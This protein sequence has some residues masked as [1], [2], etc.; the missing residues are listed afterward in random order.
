MKKDHLIYSTVQL[1]TDTGEGTGLLADLTFESGTCVPVVITNT[2]VIESNQNI[3]II[4]TLQNK[5][6]KY[7][8]CKYKLQNVV[9]KCICHEKYDLCAIP[10]SLIFKSTYSMNRA[11]VASF[12]SINEIAIADDFL[13]CDSIEDVYV[14]GYPNAF[15]DSKNNLPLARKGITATPLFADYEGDKKFLVDSGII[16][17]N[18]GSPVYF[19]TN[20]GFKLA[21]IICA[22]KKMSIEIQKNGIND[23]GLCCWIPTG[24]GIA[25]KGQAILDLAIEIKK[26]KSDI[27]LK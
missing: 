24:I 16:E 22:S 2:H 11:I 4:F 8:T 27:I 15:R 13:K 14:I 18:S 19:K 9:D 12:I 25:I 5:D 20:T 17:G 6:G 7:T 1:L 3:E 26:I 23:N 10:L 21:G